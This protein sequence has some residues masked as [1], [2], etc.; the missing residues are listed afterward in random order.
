MGKLFLFLFSVFLLVGLFASSSFALPSGTIYD[1]YLHPS[2]NE[3]WQ[4]PKDIIGDPEY[5]NIFGHKWSSPTELDIYLTWNG[6]GLNETYLGAMLGD[7]FLYNPTG[8]QDVFIP[9]RNHDST[10]D[11]NTM[12]QGKIYNVVDT[13]LSN[14]YYA[15]TSTSRYGDNELVTASSS[16]GPF[17]EATVSWISG[18]DYNTISIIGEHLKGFEDWN[19]RFAYTCGNDVHTPVTEPATMLL[20]GTGLIG[21][22]GFGRKKFKKAP[23]A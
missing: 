13:R 20:L 16:S 10:Y 22:A 2:D 6:M 12:L 7:V 9:V 23:K 19:I 17:G 5:F 14:A 21:L 1:E 4:Q 11:G 18:T 8:A 15:S 3:A